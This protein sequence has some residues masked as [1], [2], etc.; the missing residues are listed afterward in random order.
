ME[1][2]VNC[3][4]LAMTLAR[5]LDKSLAA[6]QTCFLLMEDRYKLNGCSLSKVC[7]V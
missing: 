5:L 6:Y 2:V 3:S 7:P 1:V 4:S